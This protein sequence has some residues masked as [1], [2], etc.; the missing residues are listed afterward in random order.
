MS[1]ITILW[2]LTEVQLSHGENSMSTP[3]DTLHIRYKYQQANTV[4]G[5]ARCFFSTLQGT[6][7]F[8]GKMQGM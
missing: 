5:N 8:C 2:L 7:K 6:H 4:Q 1:R 3:E